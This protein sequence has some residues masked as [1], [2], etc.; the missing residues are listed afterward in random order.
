ML[1]K[2]NLIKR[3]IIMT[4]KEAFRQARN[5]GLEQFEWGGSKYN[6]KMRI[7]T[8]ADGT[9]KVET[10]EQWRA[11][12]KKN[13]PATDQSAMT[14]TPGRLFE[15]GQFTAIG[16]PQTT[17]N[18]A[19]QS[20]KP[21]VDASNPFEPGNFHTSM[22]INRDNIRANRGTN[23]SNVDQLWDYVSNHG[24]SDEAQLFNNVLGG[25]EGDN[26]KNAF[27]QMMEK[28]K[29]SGNLGR[30][31]SGRLANMFN[32]LSA[33]GT[34]GSQARQNYVDAFNTES[35]KETA[36][37]EIARQ[38]QAAKL[39]QPY[40]DKL[41]PQL[42]KPSLNKPMIGNTGINTFGDLPSLYNPLADLN[43]ISIKGSY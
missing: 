28:Y 13:A 4:F 2:I 1:R 7:G 17:I 30:R 18:G 24:E 43:G 14:F 12:L 6:T 37:M 21:V 25:L 36:K 39:A 20:F 32:D 8:N 11:A 29:I 19:L 22:T 10:D 5:Q 38:Q 40:A 33:I 26:K 42:S 9:P 3:L 27:M 16:D 15:N 35:R 41:T 23:Y 31:D 34:E